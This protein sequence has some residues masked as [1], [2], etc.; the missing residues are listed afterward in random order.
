MKAIEVEGLSKNFGESRVLDSLTFSIPQGEI[1]GFLGPNG[2]GKTTA[3][4]V[5]NGILEKTEGR[6]NIH[7]IDVRENV[8][9]AHR[10]SGVMTET[11]SS[12]ENLTAWE[13]LDFFGKLYSM[14]KSEISSRSEELLNTL[15]LYEHKDKKVKA[16]STGMKKRMSLA[17][18]LLHSPK[19]LFLDEPTSGLDPESARSV[20]HMIKRLAKEHGVTV[21]LCTHQLK[22]AEEICSLYGFLNKGRLIGFGTFEEL[23][24]EKN[25]GIHLNIRG[26]NLPSEYRGYLD[27]E[28]GIYRLPISGDKE[29]S[30]IVNAIVSAGGDIYEADQSHWSLEDLYFAYQGG[31]KK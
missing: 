21:F 20:S 24:K 25:S 11:A 27:E 6:V 4:R 14:E 7:G 18:A 31:E 8:A 22:Y 15:G 16:Y 30:G 29:A 3:V 9:E 2:S 19:V 17:R 23:L 13:N 26:D 12:Y 5:I 1:F 10:I 28:S